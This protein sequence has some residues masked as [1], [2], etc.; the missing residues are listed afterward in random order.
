[1]KL[2]SMHIDNFG[3]LHNYD[4][5]FSEGLN[6][7]LQD[8]GWGKTTMAAFLKAMLYGFDSKRSRDITENERKRYIPW[9]G[10][11]YGGS[12]DFEA[13]GQ[14]YRIYRSFGE[15]PRFDKVKILKLDTKTTAKID[16]DKIGETL[17]RLDASAFQRSVFINQNG[18]SIDGA[19]SS[20]H[21]R[22]NALVSQANDVAA[23][24]EAIAKL[25]AQIKIYEKKGAKGKIG[26]IAREISG[27]E[28]QRDKLETDI[29]A[30]DAARE[31]ITQIDFFL[32]AIN[33]DIEQKKKK[34]DEVSGEAKKRE[35]SKKLLEDING[36]IAELQ[37]QIAALKTDFGGHVPGQNEVDAAKAQ[38]Q[39][40]K[41]LTTQLAELEAVHEKLAADYAALIEKY[42]GSLPS[43]AQLDELQGI[44][45][46]L[47][48]ILST[49]NEEESA[50]ERTAAGYDT[51]KAAADADTDYI[52]KLKITLGS[53]LM[54]QQLQRELEAQ[55]R[56]LAQEADSW[57]E[58]QRRYAA[59][60]ANVE[61]RQAE[62]DA[63][64]MYAPAVTEPVIE[65]LEQ[66]QKRQTELTR[67]KAE[68]EAAIERAVSD[69]SNK[70]ARFA[71][72]KAESEKLNS[73]VTAA[74]RYSTEKISPAVK[75][76]E[77]IQKSTQTVSAKM[78]SLESFEL[79]PEQERLLSDNSGE[80]PDADEA[81]EIL[82]KQRSAAAHQSEIQGLSARLE[83]EKTKAESLKASIEQLESASGNEEAPL[84][85]P[86]KSAARA[87][88]GIG[89]VL[90]LLGAISSFA[91]TPLVSVV[92]A[93]GML[94]MLF[95][96]VSRK[97]YKL[98][99]QAYE[100]NKAQAA[101]LRENSRRKLE[102]QGQLEAVLTA[103][104]GIEGEIAEHKR[105]MTE[106][107]EVVLAWLNKWAADS[108]PAEATI[109]ELID[110]AEELGR[111]RKKK[112]E[113][114]QLQSF[115]AKQTEAAERDRAAIDL[116]YPEL[117][118]K[119]VDETL[120]L[121]RSAET[122]YKIKA[123]KLKSA[124]EGLERFLAET[125][126]SETNY[127]ADEAPGLDM[128]HARLKATE[129]ELEMLETARKAIDEQYPELVGQAYEA[130]LSQLRWK[131]SAYRV[132]E[133]QLQAALR[134]ESSFVDEEK[135]NHEEL[136]LPQSP[137]IAKM[138]EARNKTAE[139]LTLALA[140]ANEQLSAIG[141][142]ITAE[143]AQTVLRRA[144]Q[145]F[146]AYEQ[147]AARLSERAERR[148]KKQ[149]QIKELQNKLD[150]KL[151]A[152]QGCYP[153]LKLP[154]R[155]ALIR[156]NVAE[157][158]K[159]Q[160]KL[161][162]S[163]ENQRK[164]EL[165]REEASNA[166]EKF[167]AAYGHFEAEGTDVPAAIYAKAASYS[168][169]L[170]AM[171]QLE[172][173]RD[174]IGDGQSTE[175][176]HAGVEETELKAQ[177]AEAE[178]RRDALLIEYTQK[179]DFIRQADES[180]EKYPD[181]STEIRRLYEQ[182]RRAQNTL[183]ML[184]KTIL[185]ISRAKENLANRYLSKVEQR[186][187]NYMHIWLNSDAVRGILDLDFN[188]SIEENEKQHVAEGYSTGYCDLIDFCMRLALIDTLFE[189]EQ[190]F[191]ILDDPFVNLDVERL[192]K[193]LE[194]L[195]VMAAS[196]QII[197][198]VCHPIRAVEV[199]EN[200]ASRAEFVQL[201]E[202]TRKTLVARKSS[203]AVRKK[204][205]RKSPKELYKLA[206]KGAAPAFRPAKPSY[207]ITNNIFSLSFVMDER[208]SQKDSSYEL[209]FIDAN[210]HVLNERQ[211]IE[212]KGGKLSTERVQFCLNSRDDSGEQYELMIRESG[213]EDYEVVAR[214][215][216]KAK[217]AFTGTDS[218]DF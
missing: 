133:G 203:G 162:A 145:M 174:A 149:R 146:T 20:I 140:E 81:R 52:S 35:A 64:S 152:L 218:F 94:L 134:A 124:N 110:N 107:R 123:D 206:D 193:A 191:L 61:A 95:G 127:A 208:S 79:S 130:A 144:E 177:I 101:K 120:T 91:L 209:F 7:V 92:A 68:Q 26:D 192:D 71:A 67:E 82:K 63:L 212:I 21:T 55:E 93:I 65:K 5:T 182:K 117:T 136:K 156:E 184:K 22:L 217:L 189:S 3:G 50:E 109:T 41:S 147:Q 188:I 181:V 137:R 153:D 119:S 85:E 210:G 97:N 83:G 43:A 14:A 27:L 197:Y 105:Q 87:M 173:Q 51:V 160:E 100:K 40:L 195:N 166:L 25:T 178:A 69:W 45:G 139:A 102:L 155:L 86:K 158:A 44:Y 84:D 169:L 54:L 48:G 73:A 171:Q 13:E 116:Q 76:L 32:A 53:Q 4:F 122:D 159:L 98:K 9:Q 129:N 138:R 77:D 216:F 157:A 176:H 205:I 168:A 89:A 78:E 183:I 59:L 11:A 38:Q 167:T 36:Q 104:A 196:K 132:S 30:Q 23:F 215:P 37:A 28:A 128:L 207:T 118:G 46:E 154:E 6:I 88:L 34:L 24:D 135:L 42:M 172:K 17:F 31:R 126:M 163:E 8:N 106:E 214:I 161:A 114:S 72:L 15:T 190:P 185:L 70:K 165:K 99:L 57:S 12:L 198:F 179:S 170:T 175:T 33:E 125:M 164:L 111:L 90:T 1:M 201:A 143:N 150:S 200:S 10:G 47:Q 204:P 60:R 202:A 66:Q 121:L 108:K 151:P 142:R 213:Q 75:T 62:T 112:Q 194:L 186:F 103:A 113:I 96:A 2:L 56:S 18:L 80:L 74:Q 19:A 180:L 16:P 115:I 199:D 39:T 131:L 141:L 29:L 49:R 211:L 148:E 187:N 58:T